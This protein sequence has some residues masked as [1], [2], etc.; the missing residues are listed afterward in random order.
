MDFDKEATVF[1]RLCPC[2][3]AAVAV[4]DAVAAEALLEGVAHRPWLA[5][6]HRA[7]ALVLADGVPAAG[8]R[9][10]AGVWGPIQ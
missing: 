7:A 6:A 10:G 9:D 3:V 4:G 5:A 1:F 2:L 8:V